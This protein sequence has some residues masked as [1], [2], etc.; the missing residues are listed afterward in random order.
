MDIKADNFISRVNQIHQALNIPQNFATERKLPL[1]PEAQ[2]LV[3]IISK[4]SDKIH[5]LTPSTANA[6][7]QMQEAAGT[8]SISLILISGYRGLEYQRA[9]IEKKL[10]KGQT[11]EE[12]LTLLAPPGYSEHHTGTA[13]DL[14]TENC[15]P[16]VERFEK[17]DAFNWLQQNAASFD[18]TLSYPRD[19][20]YGFVY[21]PWHWAHKD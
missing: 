21:E 6:W 4:G 8:D 20:P 13:I 9:L 3:E 18:F 16:C 12:I 2:S 14:T 17:T 19:N 1:H 7:T 5:K 15:P 11:I 10:Q